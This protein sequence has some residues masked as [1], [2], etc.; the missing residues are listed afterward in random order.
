M[1]VFFF[2]L[3][4]SRKMFLKRRTE[5]PNKWLRNERLFL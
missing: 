3:K 2:S 1:G 5:G 4:K